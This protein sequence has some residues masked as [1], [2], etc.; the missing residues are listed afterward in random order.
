M[1][2]RER[3]SVE[4]NG[5]THN[6]PGQNSAHL[7]HSP[8]SCSL[9]R[10]CTLWCTLR[11]LSTAV[12]GYSG[13]TSRLAV[14]MCAVWKSRKGDDA[15]RRSWQDW[16]RGALTKS[17]CRPANKK[18]LCMWG[19]RFVVCG[20][21]R[22]ERK[23][24]LVLSSERLFS[25]L[26]LFVGMYLFWGHTKIKSIWRQNPKCLYFFFQ[27][28]PVLPPAGFVFVLLYAPAGLNHREY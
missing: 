19:F 26:S 6:C 20:E 18:A 9:V 25:S 24:V 17:E 11:S 22:K 28:V 7:S 15:R 5:Y 13:S 12:P 14:A 23:G 10:D 16:S 21:R 2:I 8:L 4:V 3:R 27:N 1:E